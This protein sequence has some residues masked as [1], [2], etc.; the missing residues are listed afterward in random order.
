MLS[1]IFSEINSQHTN[2]I[3]VQYKKGENIYL[4]PIYDTKDQNGINLQNWNNKEIQKQ[5]LSSS[6]FSEYMYMH[7]NKKNPKHIRY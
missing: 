4:V 6:A 5:R 7:T 1:M 3:I 2:K